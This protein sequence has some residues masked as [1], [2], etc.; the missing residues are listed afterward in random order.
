MSS[1]SDEVT[2]LERISGADVALSVVL[3]CLEAARCLA[4][5][6]WSAREAQESPETIVVASGWPRWC[7]AAVIPG[8]LVA[9]LSQPKTQPRPATQNT[10]DSAIPARKIF[11]E[12]RGKIIALESN[13]ASTRLSR[14]ILLKV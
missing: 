1:I 9:R 5:Q 2:K 14:W 10:S 8:A 11:I 3:R 6:L 7:S 13:S 12:V 4:Q